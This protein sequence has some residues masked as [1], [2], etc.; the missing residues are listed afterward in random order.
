[1]WANNY[2]KSRQFKFANNLGILLSINGIFRNLCSQETSL[3]TNTEWSWS[4]GF[5]QPYIKNTLFSSSFAT[6]LLKNIVSEIF[7]AAQSKEKKN[8]KKI[9]GH[10]WSHV[11][12]LFCDLTNQHFVAHHGNH[13]CILLWAIEEKHHVA[14]YLCVVGC[15][16][17][18]GMWNLT[19]C[20]D[21]ND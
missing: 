11:H 19:I 15:I 18:C 6:A 21:S 14:Y 5:S 7:V 9:H 8:L 3:E 4:V 17:A 10:L 12:S 13:G 20:E 1:M 2:K 16:R